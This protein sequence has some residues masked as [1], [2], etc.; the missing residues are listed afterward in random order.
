MNDILNRL[1][2]ELQKSHAEQIQ[3]IKS[4]KIAQQPHRS[5]EIKYLYAALAKAQA[6]MGIASLASENPYFKSRYADLSAIVKASRPALTKN[7]LAISQILLTNDDGANLLIT[8]MGH[9][10]GQFLESRLRILPPKNDV[11]TLGSYITYLRRYSYAALVGIVTGDEDDDAET[12]VADQRQAFAK[13]PASHSYKPKE[14]SPEAITREQ[15]QELEI[16][17]SDSPDI[18]E[19][20]LDK[21]QLQSLADMPKIKYHTAIRRVREIKLLRSN[22]DKK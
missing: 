13:G 21:M 17:L 11:Q 19:E 4:S 16:E 7:G 14:N 12:V 3:E 10:S 1:L 15:L 20:I 6:E 2:D 9:S 22:P 8:T 5:T 18:A